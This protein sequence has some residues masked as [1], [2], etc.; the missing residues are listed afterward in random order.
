VFDIATFAMLGQRLTA[1]D[2]ASQA[3]FHTGWFVGN[4][5]TQILA[6]QVIRTA[7]VPVLGSRASTAFTLATAAGCGLAVLIPYSPAAPLLGLR[8]LP[9]AVL[10][11]LMVMGFGYLASLQGGKVLYRRATGRWL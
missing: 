4:L 9:P 1:T 7:R 10:V 11:T 3:L 8:P 6:V 5:L 2:P